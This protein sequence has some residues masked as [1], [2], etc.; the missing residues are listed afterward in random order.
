MQRCCSDGGT[1]EPACMRAKK[2]TAQQHEWPSYASPCLLSG[3]LDL[4]AA[5]GLP[6]THMPITSGRPQRSGTGPPHSR[7]VCST[8]A[9][10]RSPPGHRAPRLGGRISNSLVVGTASAPTSL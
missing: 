9:G 2:G 6:R 3:Y 5:N 1:A 8:P 7:G 4:R 10:P